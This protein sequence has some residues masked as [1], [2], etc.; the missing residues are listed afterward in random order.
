MI[1]SFACKKTEKL[2]NDIDVAAFRS[3]ANQARRRLLY[4]DQ[5]INV[6]D[7]RAPPSNRLETLVGK[8]KGQWSIRINKKW[9]VCF[10]W[11][12]GHAYDV[13]ISDYH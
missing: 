4:L 9:R 7:L 3:F 12:N 2:F 1:K 13:E 11:N 10:R 8:R 6:D 5:A